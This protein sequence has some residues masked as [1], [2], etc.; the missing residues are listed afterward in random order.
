MAGSS[1]HGFEPAKL[2]AIQKGPL[3][4]KPQLSVSTTFTDN[5]NYREE[6]KLSDLLATVSPGFA[7]QLGAKDANHAEL[8]YFY[9]RIQH[10]EH[11]EFSANQHRLAIESHFQRSRFTLV[12][13]DKI[14]F[15]SSPLGGGYSISGQMVD[16]TTFY[17]FYRLDY[18][19]TERTGIYGAATHSATDYQDDIALYD[20]RTLTGTLGFTYKAFSRTAL[21][22]E[23]YYG[24]TESEKN[25]P[26]LAVYPNATFVGGFVGARGYFTEKLTGT[27]KVGY[28]AREYDLDNS[29]GSGAPVVDAAL[30][31]RFSEHTSAALAYARRQQE[32]VQF[33]SSTYV[34]DSISA[35]LTQIFGS[36]ERLRGVLQA[37]YAA[38]S[39]EQS[40]AFAQKREDDLISAGLTFTYDVKLWMR[41]FGGYSF[42]WLE[43][44]EASLA[45]YQVN[46]VTV[47]LQLGY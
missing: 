40:L 23:V 29:Q 35:S 8:T 34:S 2:F 31:F 28:E 26:G 16:R 47:G 13:Q 17:D 37:G 14:E 3:L 32:S 12:G 42:E 24:Q 11:T 1:A 43:S 39:Y 30:A 15:L 9:D 25:A 41:L 20:S 44:T 27:V 38:S 22:G 6:D 7:L 10:L 45:D 21:F 46:R 5:I 33:V 36:D 19:L 18:D 4:L